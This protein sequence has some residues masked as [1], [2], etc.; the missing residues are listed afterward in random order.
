MENKQ[1]TIKHTKVQPLV[2]EALIRQGTPGTWTNLHDWTYECTFTSLKVC[3]LKIPMS[4]TWYSV[5]KDAACSG[6]CTFLEW[7]SCLGAEDEDWE[8]AVLEFDLEKSRIG[9]AGGT[10]HAKAQ[11]QSAHF[12]EWCVLYMIR[13]YDQG[14]TRTLGRDQVCHIKVKGDHQ[15]AWRTDPHS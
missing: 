9:Q 6:I 4:E 15:R 8:G 5:T 13:V 12:W 10:V 7:S 3:S 1:N 11:K 2:D 14:G